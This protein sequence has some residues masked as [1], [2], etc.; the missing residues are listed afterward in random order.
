MCGVKFI[1]MKTHFSMKGHEDERKHF[2]L[3]R[4]QVDD[5]KKKKNHHGY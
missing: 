4:L 5:I 1:F 2:S 3:C